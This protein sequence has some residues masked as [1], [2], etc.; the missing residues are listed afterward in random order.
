LL[1]WWKWSAVAIRRGLTG[2]RAGV[3][4]LRLVVVIVA[5]KEGSLT[6]DSG[7]NGDNGRRIDGRW[8]VQMM[9][10]VGDRQQWKT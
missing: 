1:T 10:Q 3:P 2:V 4:H 8:V 6:S 5:V 9:K 7:R